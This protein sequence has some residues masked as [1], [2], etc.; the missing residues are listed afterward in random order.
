MSSSEGVE[1]LAK[2]ISD[3]MAF[4]EA[5]LRAIAADA[6]AAADEARETR[7]MFAA[8]MNDGLDR[9]KAMEDREGGNHGT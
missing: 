6:T 4:F 2:G 7:E 9:L 8:V 1:K 5:K 3:A